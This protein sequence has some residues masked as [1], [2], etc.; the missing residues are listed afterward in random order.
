[1]GAAIGE[2]AGTKGDF[3]ANREACMCLLG[4]LVEP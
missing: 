2:L 1:M 4:A 3:A